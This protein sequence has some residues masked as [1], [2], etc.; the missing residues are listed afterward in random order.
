LRVAELSRGIVQALWVNITDAGDLEF[1][2]GVEGGGVVHAALAH[3]DD[4]DFVFAHKK[5]MEGFVMREA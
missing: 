3:T 5:M 4:E 2:V 1:R